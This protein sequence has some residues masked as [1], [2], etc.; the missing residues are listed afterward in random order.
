MKIPVT[1]TP[2][3][4]NITGITL[5]SLTAIKPAYKTDPKRAVT[6]EWECV[7]GG[8]TY[9]EYAVLKRVNKSFDNPAVP[10][11]GC[12]KKQACI[13]THQTHGKTGHPL[14]KK[15]YR[16]FH[17]CY[18]S[19]TVGYEYYGGKGVTMCQEWLDDPEAFIAWGLAN[20]YKP[21]LH[22]DKDVLCKQQNISPAIYSPT[23]CQFLTPS[24]HSV[25]TNAMRY[26]K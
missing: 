18:S 19:Y 20:G 25:I 26:T 9:E 24:E 15:Y 11:C 3:M 22:I 6:W 21:G 4:N 14:L 2:K 16:I 1:L 8:T 13:D 5:G 12:A 23:T 7:C 17:R 10:S